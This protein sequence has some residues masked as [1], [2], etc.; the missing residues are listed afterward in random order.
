MRIALLLLILLL[1]GPALSAPRHATR[2]AVDKSERKLHVYVDEAS[3]T[4]YP[5]ALGL[6]PVGHKQRQG[7]RRTPEGRYVLDYKNPNSAFYRSI[8]VSYPNQADAERARRQGVHP[9]GDIMIHGQP[10]DP[11]LRQRVW[12]YFSQDWTDGCIA[13]SDADMKALW[14]MVRVPTPIEITP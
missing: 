13:L 10:N 8:H 11:A 3:V 14:E 6:N 9:G 12:A 1:A 2:I 7:D 4:T 5:V